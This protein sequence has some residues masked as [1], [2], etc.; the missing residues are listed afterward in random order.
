MPN[1]SKTKSYSMI[2]RNILIISNDILFPCL[3]ETLLYRK[4]SNLKI[5]IAKSIKDVDEMTADYKADITLLDSILDSVTSFEVMRHLRMDKQVKTPIFFFPDTKIEP[6]IYKSYVM[7][8][9][10]IIQKPFDPYI[11][12]DEIAIFLQS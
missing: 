12:T 5:F 11:I 4:I 1:R 7:G 6:Y 2:K 9:S 3:F 8:A 10:R